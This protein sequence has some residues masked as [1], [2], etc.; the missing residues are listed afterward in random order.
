MHLQA[1]AISLIALHCLTGAV[2]A[3]FVSVPLTGTTSTDSWGEGFNNVRY[4]GYGAYPGTAAWPN[5]IAPDTEGSGNASLNKTAGSGY[6][7]TTTG[8]NYIYSTLSG[9][10]AAN[11]SAANV[12]GTFSVAET[13][14]VASLE[15]V[16]FQ[17]QISYWTAVGTPFPTG[18][19][20]VLNYNGGNQALQSTFNLLAYSGS[21]TSSFGTGTADFWAFQW[22]LSEVN[23]S[24]TSFEVVY[25]VTNH[26]QTYAL[27]LDQGDTFS[28]VVPEP[29]SV[30]LLSLGGSLAFIRRRR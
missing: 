5:P 17:I 6:P 19:M 25:S 22:D 10:N 20:P 21:F 7:S 16:V 1:S 2:S 30:F 26:A 9:G 27:K 14:P 4:P 18:V 29:S 23:E 13:S 8:Q 11:T 28:K 24:I 15:T 3:S 12:V